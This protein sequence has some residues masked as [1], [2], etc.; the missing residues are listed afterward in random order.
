M[1]DEILIDKL[2]KFGMTRQESGIYLCIYRNGAMTGYEIAKLTG[3]SRSNVYSSI[4]SLVDKGAAMLLEGT[5]S[6]YIA[7]KIADYTED[8]MKHLEEDRKEL[9]SNAPVPVCNLEGYITITGYRH[10]LD[11]VHHMFKEAEYRIYLSAPEDI[12]VLLGD[13]I[14]NIVRKNLKFVVITDGFKEIQKELEK[15]FSEK[16]ISEIAVYYAKKRA[17][18]LRL[19]IDSK[20]VLTGELTGKREDTAL[21]S[22]QTNF[23][24]VFKEALHNEMELIRIKDKS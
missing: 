1:V 22:A 12:V 18:Q 19:I 7:V 11:K 15:D 24:N 13:D 14:K 21:Y 4:A 16:E 8:Y 9:I 3:I 23:V 10:I 5:A 17:T 2:M 6:K 20:Y